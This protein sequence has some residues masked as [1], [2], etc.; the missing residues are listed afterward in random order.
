[1]PGPPDSVRDRLGNELKNIKY[2]IDYV[3]ALEKYSNM[4]K[5]Y[6]IVLT[7]IFKSFLK[8][9]RKKTMD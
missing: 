4:S 9:H 2:K 3:R 8:D 6:T 5:N 7:N 1:M